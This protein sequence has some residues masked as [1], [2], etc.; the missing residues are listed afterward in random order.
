MKDNW[1]YKE[2]DLSNKREIKRLQEEIDKLK[3]RLKELVEENT[4]F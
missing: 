2:Q 4:K 3:M 1:G